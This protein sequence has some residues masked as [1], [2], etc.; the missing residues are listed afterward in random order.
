MILLDP[1]EGFVQ[2]FGHFRS[3]PVLFRILR[4]PVGVV[5]SQESLV[6][7]FHRFEVAFEGKFQVGVIL[8]QMFLRIRSYRVLTMG[9]GVGSIRTIGRISV[10]VITP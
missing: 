3:V 4:E 1:V 8:P 10:R 5:F 7:L 9:S 2:F 6:L